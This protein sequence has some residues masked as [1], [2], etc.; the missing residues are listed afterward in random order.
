MA[1]GRR[2]YAVPQHRDRVVGGLALP[3]QVFHGVGPCRV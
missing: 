3:V 2:E 1:V